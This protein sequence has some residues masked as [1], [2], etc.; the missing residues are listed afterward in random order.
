MHVDVEIR[1]SHGQDD[2]E[3]HL[4]VVG[5][6]AFDGEG[7]GGCAGEP[8]RELGRGEPEAG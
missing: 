5:D 6:A 3:V 8:A 4:H 2:V 7:V 1:A